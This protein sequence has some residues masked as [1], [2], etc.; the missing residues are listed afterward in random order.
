VSTPEDAYGS[1]IDVDVTFFFD[2]GN[3]TLKQILSE[4]ISGWEFDWI[5]ATKA[6]CAE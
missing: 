6:G 3:S 1:V 4:S 2:G 5:L